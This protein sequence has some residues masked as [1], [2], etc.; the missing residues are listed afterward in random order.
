MLIKNLDQT[1][2][3]WLCNVFHNNIPVKYFLS[4]VSYILLQISKQNW[5]A[6]IDSK[7]LYQTRD[8]KWFLLDHENYFW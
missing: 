4:I 3:N 8:W 1:S 6:K 2:W 5:L 7:K